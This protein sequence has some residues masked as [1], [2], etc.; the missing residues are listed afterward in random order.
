ME[1][2]IKVG[3]RVEGI[4]IYGTRVRGVVAKKCNY[5]QGSFFAR[6]D[7]RNMP[8]SF[9]C[10]LSDVV[11]ISTS[12]PEPASPKSQLDAARLHIFKNFPR[13]FTGDRLIDELRL[14]IS[15][16]TLGPKLRKYERQ[17]LLHKDYYINDKG[18][19]IVHYQWNQEAK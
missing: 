11:L 18:R 14:T 5:Y 15:M 2:E 8:F 13:F 4:N 1:N 12:T 19:R 3:D 17:G 10:L 16:N 6:L 7:D 9:M